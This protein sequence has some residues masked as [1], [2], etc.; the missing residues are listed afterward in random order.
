M[1][2]PKRYARCVTNACPRPLETTPYKCGQHLNISAFTEDSND[3]AVYVA[4]VA[5]PRRDR[6]TAPAASG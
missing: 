4:V 5:C 3:F 2:I 1:R 6:A